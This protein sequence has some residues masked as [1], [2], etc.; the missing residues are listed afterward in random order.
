MNSLQRALFAALVVCS[1]CAPV[2]CQSDTKQ[3]PEK[4]E[5]KIYT[6]KEQR[7]PGMEKAVILEKP[8]PEFPEEAKAN[9]GD[10]YTYWEV[11]L[12]VVLLKSGEVGEI[13]VM[14]K[15]PYGITESAIRAAR[16]IKFKPAK[17]DGVPVSVYS[18]VKYSFSIR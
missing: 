8:E 6:E 13:K 3:T 12:R 10:G 2:Y 1:M 11:K 14:K 17:K 9:A 18:T 5:E 15:A 16:G 7:G 4:Q